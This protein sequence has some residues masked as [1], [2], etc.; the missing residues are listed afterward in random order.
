MAKAEIKRFYDDVCVKPEGAGFTVC[1]DGKPIKT[2]AGALALVSS[3][4]LADALAAEW[5]DQDE[6]IDPHALALTRIINSS[7]DHVGPH[8]EQIVAELTRFGQSDLICYRAEGPASL[9]QRQALHWQPLLEWASDALKAPLEAGAGVQPVIQPAASLEALRDHIAQHDDIC[10]AALHQ[11]V[12]LCGSLIIGLALSS[13][14]LT[15]AEAWAAAQVDEDWQL[16]Q[17]GDDDEAARRAQDRQT[18]L[19]AAVFVLEVCCS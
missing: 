3:K 6:R 2:P 16:E 13:G 12:S 4:K 14:R 10:L 8:R 9:V 1:L 18:A 11:A 19:S 5:D 7:L 17:W 15:E